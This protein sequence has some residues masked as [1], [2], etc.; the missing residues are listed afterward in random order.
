MRTSGTSRLIWSVRPVLAI[1]ALVS[2]DMFS[3]RVFATETAD[4]LVSD[5]ANVSAA[6][7]TRDGQLHFEPT[8][9]NGR[10]WGA[11]AAVQELSRIKLD[12]ASPPALGICAPENTTRLELIKVFSTYVRS[13]PESRAQ[14]FAVVVVL[15]LHSR[16]PCSGSG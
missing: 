12:A 3:S 9:E 7:T 15:S 2:L 5:C 13:H 10:C 4:E 14:Q 6:Q 16:Y 11:F 8:F 1:V